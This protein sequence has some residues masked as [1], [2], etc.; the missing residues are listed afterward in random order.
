M[1]P[2]TAH[3]ARGRRRRLGAGLHHLAKFAIYG[4]GLSVLERPAAGLNY[5]ASFVLVMLLH[6]TVA[7]KQPAMTAPA[8]AAKLKD[9][10]APDAIERFVDEVAHLLRSQ[11]AAIVGNL[12][13][14]APGAADLRRA[15]CRAGAAGRPEHRHTCTT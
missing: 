2:N 6:W 4:L 8:M 7:T 10:S 14:V 9:M 1:R 3:A 13:L 11:F 12:G 5:A 15:A